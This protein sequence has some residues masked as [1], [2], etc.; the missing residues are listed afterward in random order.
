MFGVLT[1]VA[2]MIP[3]YWLMLI[4]IGSMVSLFVALKIEQNLAVLYGLLICILPP[5][6]QPIPGFGGINQLFPISP[7]LLFS[8]VVLLPA[9]MH[10]KSMSG[11]LRGII[12]T[13]AF[14]VLYVALSAV[15]AFRDTSI[16]DG[17]R[18][19]WILVLTVFL[20]YF[21]ISRWVKTAEDIKVFFIAL[22]TPLLGFAAL[23]FIESVMAWH[24]YGQP[25]ANWHGPHVATYIYRL[26]FLRAY[27]S[28][29]G[30][31]EF[32]FLLMVAMTLS[33]SLIQPRLSKFM[34]ASGIAAFAGALLL[35]FSRGPWLGAV[36]ST[37]TYVVSGPKG[38]SRGI[39]AGAFA[40]L[41]FIVLALSP[42][43]DKV[44]SILPFFGDVD[45]D[46]STV[47]YRQ[48]LFENGVKV[49]M[50]NPWFG[51]TNYLE[52]PEMREL[53]QGQGIIDLVNS[54]IQ[55]GLAKGL[56]GLGLFV[57]ILFSGA[58]AAFQAMLK[59]AKTDNEF[60]GYCRA[61]FA[62]LIGVIV[63]IGTTS[64]ISQ[65]PIFYWMLA[66]LGVSVRRIAQESQSLASANG[67]VGTHKPAMSLRAAKE[68]NSAPDDDAEAA[69][70][71]KRNAERKI[72]ARQRDVPAHLRQYV[73][74]KPEDR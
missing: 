27:A 68:K 17:L 21:V 34:A 56:V 18:I 10:F 61:I 67:T 55:V 64:S 23:A 73:I 36:V 20:P 49:I 71:A 39:V 63:V 30:P 44:L 41:A 74:R 50:M 48:R 9:L 3:N 25:T 6:E 33:Y 11:K 4:V 28:V 24:F 19:I 40:V 69:A 29:L 5:I 51:S 7:P 14:M 58:N 53:L 46:N 16:T 15:L 65:V 2:F 45:A 12:L 70:H 37:A 60:S 35:T 52:T 72:A 31:I 59:T 43:G 47:S 62:A 8:I 57:G 42:I 54:Y 38:F 13:D 66:G 32:G 26:G 1:A 22:V